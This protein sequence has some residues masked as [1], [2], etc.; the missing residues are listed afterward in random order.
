MNL[1]Y[2][3]IKSRLEARV[4]GWVEEFYKLTSELVSLAGAN[5]QEL[6]SVKADCS[7]TRS[8]NGELRRQ[9]QAHCHEHGC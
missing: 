2:C 1:K 7:D 6:A 9:L 3:V 5:H 8:Y 4:F